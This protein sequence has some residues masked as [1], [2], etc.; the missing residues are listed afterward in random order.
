[1]EIHRTPSGLLIIDPAERE[2]TFA[3]LV[4]LMEKPAHRKRAM[5]MA[6]A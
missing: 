4:G 5:A 3:A 6:G 1:V 2:K